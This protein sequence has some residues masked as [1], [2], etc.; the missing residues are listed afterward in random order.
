MWKS[1]GAATEMVLEGLC[2]LGLLVSQTSQFE[3]LILLDLLEIRLIHVAAPCHALAQLER[4][5][6]RE[7][8]R[9]EVQLVVTDRSTLTGDR[10][11]GVFS[12]Q[13]WRLADLGAKHAMLKAGLGW[14]SMPEHLV[15]EDLQ[16][17][18][19]KRILASPAGEDD[20]IALPLCAA[21]RRIAPPG[22]AGRWFL[23]HLQDRLRPGR[24]K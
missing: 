24:E 4:P 11:Y 23:G 8:L 12:A 5:A 10:D 9:N 21:Y 7:D 6:T 1:L 20:A 18:R 15:T 19:L 16:A 22:P 17:G 3:P 2:A 13:T 14:G